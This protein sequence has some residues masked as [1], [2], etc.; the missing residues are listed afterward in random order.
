[1]DPAERKLKIYDVVV[2]GI[3]GGVIVLSVTLVG[4]MMQTNQKRIAEDNKTM[5]T[6]RELSAKQKEMDV[7]LGMQMFKTL[8]AHYLQISASQEGKDTEH[9][10]MI[11]RHQQMILLRMIS[12]NFQDSPINIKPLFEE[13]DIQMTDAGEKQRLRIIAMEEARHQA[14]R[15]TF[16]N[17]T[18]YEETVWKGKEIHLDTVGATIKIIEVGKDKIKASL[19]SDVMPGNPTLGPF[20]V[21]YFDTPL[22]DN[23]KLGTWR[24]SLLLLKHLG[25][26]ARVRVVIFASYLAPDRF[27]IKELT[28]QIRVPWEDKE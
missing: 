2:K 6:L 14:F 28:Q 22:N 13:L 25:D 16:Q 3:I 11:L 12:L 23:I 9:Q 1:M 24:I 20:S 26:K 5:A 7:D 21:N 15:L 4:T 10:Q 17:G 18:S 19:T 27:D 8:M